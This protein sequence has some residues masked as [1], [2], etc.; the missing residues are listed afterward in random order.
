MDLSV[1]V[2]TTHADMQA[3]AFQRMLASL[4]H[5]C[6][7]VV[8][9][10]RV[11]TQDVETTHVADDNVN[12]VHVR[13]YSCER[14][15]LDMAWLRNECARHAARAWC[16]WLDADD[17]IVSGDLA[18]LV[19]QA[20]PS[21]GAYYVNCVGMQS[22]DGENVTHYAT[23]QVRL[24]RRICGDVWI[25][26]AHEIVDVRKVA[27]LGYLTAHTDIIIHHHGYVCSRE[28]QVERLARNV[29]GVM[30]TL[31]GIWDSDAE[32]RAHYCR[33]LADNITMYNQLTG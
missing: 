15:E 19:H 7:L 22:I 6:E 28:R 10:N 32:L 9:V 27:S 4:P 33:V 16:L 2:I 29:R 25:G 31:L 3:P 12:G 24:W 20:K 21:V 8:L 23:P 18:A 17:E 14:R 13:L 11:G 30:R 26:H 1:C 5:G